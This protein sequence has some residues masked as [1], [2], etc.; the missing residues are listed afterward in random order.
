MISRLLFR[1]VWGLLAALL[2][3][4]LLRAE[5]ELV[6][7][8]EGENGAKGEAVQNLHIKDGLLVIE[9]P[10]TG[11][12]MLFSHK[13]GR[14]WI[15]NQ[16]LKS[17]TPIDPEIASKVAERLLLAENAKIEAIEK[18][19]AGLPAA[20]REQYREVIDQLHA[21]KERRNAAEKAPQTTYKEAGPAKLGDQSIEKVEAWEGDLLKCVYSL[22]PINQVGVV[23]Q[24][25][26]V[27]QEFQKFLAKVIAGLPAH[28]RGAFGDFD[29]LASDGPS[30]GR[31]PVRVVYQDGERRGTVQ[32][33][34]ESLPESR[35]TKLFA[36]PSDFAEKPLLS[37]DGTR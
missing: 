23:P 16:R 27:L 8:K 29:L 20:E 4:A 37:D 21:A 19:V 30:G 28:L 17:Y 36:V 32:I 9:T 35:N 11:Q 1:P 2:A 12:S 5:V 7:G 33:L 3:P 22:A 10:G 13:A 26:E 31:I 25:F 18:K 14:I 15:V 24:D 6:Y 34:L